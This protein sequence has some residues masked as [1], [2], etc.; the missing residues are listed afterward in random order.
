DKERPREDDPAR[1]DRGNADSRR[2]GADHG[3]REQLWI[4]ATE[5]RFLLP[6]RPEDMVRR[7]L[8]YD[9]KGSRGRTRSSTFPAH[10]LPSRQFKLIPMR[11]RSSSFVSLIP[12]LAA[13][14]LGSCATSDG[15]SID[16]AADLVLRNGRIVTM[17]NGLPEAEAVAI[18]G[19]RIVAVGSSA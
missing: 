14:A 5:M 4:T 19:D 18:S 13:V 11:I 7:P 8:A 10:P 9:P 17:D 1:A 6:S 12:V 15:S 2:E 16:A 3:C